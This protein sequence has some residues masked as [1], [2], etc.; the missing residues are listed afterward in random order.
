MKNSARC[1][2]W[3]WSQAIKAFSASTRWTKP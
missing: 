1:P 2:L 3:P